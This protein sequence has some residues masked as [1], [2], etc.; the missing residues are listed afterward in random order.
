MREHVMLDL[1]TMGNGNNAAI[2][3]IGAV[4]F[5]P[6][7][8]TG[9]A[10]PA[11]YTRITLQSS[12]QAGLKMDTSTVLWWME[13]SD[14][15]RRETFKGQSLSLLLGLSA[16]CQWFGDDKP[17]WG[18][19]ATFDNVIIRSAFAAVNIDVPWKFWNDR[20]YRTMKGLV[21]FKAE[22]LG[23]KHNALDDARSQAVHLQK[24]YQYL[25]LQG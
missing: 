18:N 17:V 2:V 16:F 23:T 25:N 13:Q 10:M 9:G 24:I 1:E 3:A 19:G 21:N 7:D 5:D 11:F 6:S 12:V 8:T 4:K 20:C 15:A 14:D 22:A